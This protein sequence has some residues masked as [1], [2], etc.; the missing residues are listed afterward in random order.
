MK[1]KLN[2]Y[3]LKNI[4]NNFYKDTLKASLKVGNYIKNG[5]GVSFKKIRKIIKSKINN[6]KNKY[7]VYNQTSNNEDII[8]NSFN[9]NCNVKNKYNYGN[10]DNNYKN[11][12]AYNK[13]HNKNNSRYY[14]KPYSNTDSYYKDAIKKIVNQYDIRNLDSTTPQFKR[15]KHVIDTGDSLGDITVRTVKRYAVRYSLSGVK[16]IKILGDTVN[17]SYKIIKNKNNIGSSA[18]NYKKELKKN[19]TSSLVSLGKL[20]AHDMIKNISEIKHSD[21]LGI[22]SIIYSKNAVFKTIKYAKKGKQIFKLVNKKRFIN[23]PF[24]LKENEKTA[25]KSFLNNTKNFF[26]NPAMLK[27]MG[28]LS[29]FICVFLLIVALFSGVLGI[30]SSLSLKSEDVELSKTYLYITQLDTELEGNI[31]NNKKY[32]PH[33]YLNGQP[34][35]IEQMKVYTNADLLLAYLDCKYQDFKFTSIIGKSVKDEVTA[36]HKAMHTVTKTTWVNNGDKHVDINLNTTPWEDFYEKNKDSLLNESQKQQYEA[37]KEVGI[38]TF[39]KVLGSPFIGVNWLNNVSSRWGWRVHPILGSVKIHLGLDIAMNGGTPI[40]ACNDGTVFLNSSSSG[41]GNH[42]KIVDDNGDY[43]LYAHLSG[44]NVKNGQKIKKGEIIGF[45]GTT[46]NSTGNHLHLEYHK[47][48]NN[49]NPLIF[50]EVDK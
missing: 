26:S 37:L 49:L 12:D 20:A 38:Y 6:E 36:I 14:K 23:N 10:R 35:S 24:S 19:L 44:F 21:D 32:I 43:T 11:T 31:K 34:A 50:V 17:Q 46:G 42:I 5:N 16:S 22:Q 45:V 8:Y 9:N 15:N 47:N 27:T 1:E 40:N 48:G 41:Y 4:N 39:R 33:Y 2:K 3:G 13:I 30:F 28:V 18:Y 25:Y 7:G 29:L